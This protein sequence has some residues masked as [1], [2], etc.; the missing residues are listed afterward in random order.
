MA[1]AN[2]GKAILGNTMKT[3]IV[4]SC[5]EKYIPAAKALRN[6]IVANSNHG[7]ELI[8][9]AHGNEDAYKEV[10]PLYDKVIMNAE[11]VA[12][13]IGGEWTY[14]M[15]AM[16]SR[17]LIPELFADYDRVLWLDADI[18]VLQDL[19]HLLTMD[20][21]GKPCA[22]TLNSRDNPLNAGNYQLE[23]PS[24][25][26]ESYNITAFNAGVILFDIPAWNKTDISEKINKLLLGD[27]KFKYVVQGVMS[28]AIA[29]NY[30]QL[31]F[32][33]NAYA[34]WADELGMQNVKIIHWVGGHQVMPWVSQTHN[35]HIWE[36]YK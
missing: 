1:T 13:P 34:H 14:E 26:P 28:M 20:L 21:Q 8:L 24:Q 35:Q 12:S 9:L 36:Q 15:P 2:M 33:Y 30:H 31:D 19:E 11:A 25:M 29:S 22:A 5:D 23:D 7:A 17:V 16:Y 18:I 27:I 32:T 3:A 4:T 10:K 6:S